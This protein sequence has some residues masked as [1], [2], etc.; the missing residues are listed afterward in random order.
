MVPTFNV[1]KTLAL[2]LHAGLFLSFHSP[3]N[4]YIDY[5]IFHV[6]VGTLREVTL[7]FLFFFLFL[8]NL[9]YIVL[10]EGLVVE[11]TQNLTPEKSQ[12]KV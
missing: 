10:S 11:Y 2:L 12:R 7:S 6:R 8:I 5:W 4:S 3:P 1:M 9:F